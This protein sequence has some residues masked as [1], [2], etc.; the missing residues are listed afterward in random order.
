MNCYV[1][2]SL[3]KTYT[4]WSRCDIT[5]IYVDHPPGTFIGHHHLNPLSEEEEKLIQNRF[6]CDVPHLETIIVHH[7]L[8]P[9]SDGGV[10][11]YQNR[12]ICYT[13]HL[14][15]MTLATLF[16]HIYLLHPYLYAWKSD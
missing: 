4:S 3:C 5:I 9:L 14:G 10:T 2:N 16:T 15:R 1:H 13:T 8:N 7:L 6:G 12:F 11:I